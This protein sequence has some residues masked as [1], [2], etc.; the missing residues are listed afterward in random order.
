MFNSIGLPGLAL[1]ALVVLV[2][3]GRGRIAALM[4]DV[5]KGVTAFRRGLKDDERLNKRAPPAGDG[6]R[7]THA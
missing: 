3:F 5:G 4:G 7:E 6:K 1:I 2:L